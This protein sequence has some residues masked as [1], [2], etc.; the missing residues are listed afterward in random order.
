MKMEERK[1]KEVRVLL[2]REQHLKHEISIRSQ[3]SLI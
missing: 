2:N 3:V 1:E